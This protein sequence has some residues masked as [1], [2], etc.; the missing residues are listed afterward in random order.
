M[1]EDEE[2]EGPES[3]ELSESSYLVPGFANLDDLLKNAR[4]FEGA[5]RSNP[6]TPENENRAPRQ[7]DEK[8]VKVMG[9]YEQQGQ[10]E[11]PE[12]FVLLRDNQ[13]RLVPIWIGQFEAVA[14][15]VALAGGT[16]PRP[17]THDLLKIV[18]DRLGGRVERVVI[19]DLWERTY[20]A[21]LSITADGNVAE[22]DCRP[23][24]AIA[25]GLRANAPI[26]MAE[27]VLAQ[28][29]ITEET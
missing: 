5:D 29:A 27:A 9:V 28:S 15:S 7:L 16:F 13:D 21:K 12:T 6:P 14:I 18:I 22:I 8:E 2:F 20:Y 19:D 10:E 3:E 23:S 17:M 25:V 26:Y 11:S 24:D 4:A 1:N